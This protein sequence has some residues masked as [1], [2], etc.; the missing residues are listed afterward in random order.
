[1]TRFA[2]PVVRLA[3]ALS[4]AALSTASQ[5][6]TVVDWT[7][8]SAGTAGGVGV[9][10]SGG[11]KNLISDP[12]YVGVVFN[13]A[14]MTAPVGTTEGIEFLGGTSAPIT[15]TVTFDSMVTGV[16]L[17]IGSLASTLVFDRPVTRLS[18]QD[19]FK[20]VGNEVSGIAVNGGAFS[21]MNGSIFL[22]DLQSFYFT[23]SGTFP[24]GEGIGL[25]IVTG[26]TAPVP[27]P[28]SLLLLAAGLAGLG[29][30]LRGRLQP[31]A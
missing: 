25:Q 26:M 2:S 10:F 11:S 30:R 20:V 3:A 31:S 19:D 7:S 24:N 4:L 28:A 23:A 18:G 9:T 14:N 27:E 12:S 21:D 17:H 16:M 15:Y 1:M 6:Q 5:A 13:L 29:L 22:G 8:S